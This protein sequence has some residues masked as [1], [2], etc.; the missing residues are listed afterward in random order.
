[1]RTSKAII[2]TIESIV[3]ASGK[4]QD[5][6][7]SVAMECIEHAKVNGDATLFQRLYNDLPTGQRKEA[8]KI[9]GAKYTP[10]RITEQGRTV[11]LAGKKDNREWL[12]EEAN[13]NPYHTLDERKIGGVNAAM[14]DFERMLQAEYDKHAFTA[15]AMEHSPKIVTI[16]GQYDPQEAMSSV[17]KVA[18]QMRI[19]LDA[20]SQDDL[21]EKLARKLS[22]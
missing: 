7:H 5:R 6:I 2:K 4:L 8:L 10:I 11:K 17:Q 12:I 13:A 18:R 3:A 1:M 9:W 16:K 15:Y 22:A 21:A 19:E 20:P 14:P